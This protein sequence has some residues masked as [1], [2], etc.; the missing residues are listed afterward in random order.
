M[1]FFS[2]SG[3]NRVVT[4][5]LAAALAALAIAG[6]SSGPEPDGGGAAGPRPWEKAVAALEAGP[7]GPGG[8][9]DGL[10][11]TIS[12]LGPADLGHFVNG[13]GE[14]RAFVGM[15]T[16]VE[17]G[18]GTGEEEE[19]GGA[20]RRAWAENLYVRF[21]A[22]LVRVRILRLLTPERAGIKDST[23]AADMAR[24]SLRDLMDVRRAAA[25]LSSPDWRSAMSPFEGALK[26]DAL[27]SSDLAEISK[28]WFLR[29]IGSQGLS[30]AR[31]LRAAVAARFFGYGVDVERRNFP[32]EAE[33]HADRLGKAFESWSA[34]GVDEA[35]R[36]LLGAAFGAAAGPDAG[37]TERLL[38]LMCVL[39]R[40][41]HGSDLRARAGRS[42]AG[43]GYAET[44]SPA[45]VDAAVSAMSEGGEKGAIA[46]VAVLTGEDPYLML[47]IREERL[48][49]LVSALVGG[50]GADSPVIRAYCA[51]QIEKVTGCLLAEY[52]PF[53][54]KAEL[55]RQAGAVRDRFGRTG[56][57]KSEEEAR[58]KLVENRVRKTLEAVAALKSI[59]NPG[60][61]AVGIADLVEESSRRGIPIGISIE[62]GR[63]ADQN[64][65]E[66]SCREGEFGF[67]VEARG[68]LAQGSPVVVFFCDADAG[69][70]QVAPSGG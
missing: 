3:G 65:F 25:R 7:D 4:A 50:L 12:S 1:A 42:P 57:E 51:S 13:L 69:P 56:L 68:I 62:G 9:F 35:W 45:L 40:A 36:G 27:R 66:Y 17:G 18:G 33:S 14:S 32:R 21:G 53:S 37:S 38:W 2:L 29:G 46:A 16:E 30:G 64:G 43:R 67:H 19:G 49:T 70:S 59:G 26:G 61:A 60:T 47:R 15:F 23:A 24:V 55:D 31:A 41:G 52:D 44:F 5:R 8:G 11:S 39:A 28:L 6:C 20:I 54:E 58:R 22:D 34:G 48:G 10:R 63:A